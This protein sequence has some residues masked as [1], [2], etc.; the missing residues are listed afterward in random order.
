MHFYNLKYHAYSES[1]YVYFFRLGMNLLFLQMKLMFGWRDTR[2]LCSPSATRFEWSKYLL[3]ILLTV[4]AGA[5]A[6]YKWFRSAKLGIPS[7]IKTLG[8]MDN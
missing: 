2:I 8:T 5:I 4:V 7:L 1:I 3:A 6:A